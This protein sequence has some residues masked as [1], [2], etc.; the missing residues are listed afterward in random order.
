M[1]CN[2]NCEYCANT[3]ICSGNGNQ[4]PDIDIEDDEDTGYDDDI[5]EMNSLADMFYL[6]QRGCI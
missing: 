5:D 4:N 3:V 2:L 1:I 6:S